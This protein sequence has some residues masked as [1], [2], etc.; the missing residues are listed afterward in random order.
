MSA[1]SL[2]A[3]SLWYVVVV[4]V[5]P[6]EKNWWRIAPGGLNLA[7]V[8]GSLVNSVSIIGLKLWLDEET[9]R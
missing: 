8:C 9:F 7:T 1:L 3:G 5:V 6:N 4:L 2:T